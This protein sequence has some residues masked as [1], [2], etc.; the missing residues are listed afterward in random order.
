MPT[1]SI[2]KKILRIK[3]LYGNECLE[4]QFELTKEELETEKQRPNRCLVASTKKDGGV[5]NSLEWFNF[6]RL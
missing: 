3:Q 1:E 4:D 5:H 2:A 6:T